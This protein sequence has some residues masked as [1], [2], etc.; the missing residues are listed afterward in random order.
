MERPPGSSELRETAR[1]WA[2]P[3]LWTC[4]TAAWLFSTLFL[5]PSLE[6]SLAGVL[7]ENQQQWKVATPLLTSAAV[8]QLCLPLVLLRVLL[9]G[10]VLKRVTTILSAIWL[11]VLFFYCLADLFLFTRFGRHITDVLAYLS[12]PEGA[13]AG[14]GALGWWSTVASLLGWSLL[15]AGV[16]LLLAHAFRLAMVRLSSSMRALC[17]GCALLAVLALCAS[18]WLLAPLMPDALRSRVYPALALRPGL[19]FGTDQ[20]EPNDPQLRKLQ[21]ELQRHYGDLFSFVYG[22]QEAD[23]LESL[24]DGATNLSAPNVSIVVAESLRWEMLSERHMPRLWRLAQEGLS[25]SRHYAATNHSE[26]GLFVLLYG[27]SALRYNS[28]LDQ[29]TPPSLCH[30]VR[31]LGYRC[32]YY[33]GHPQIWLR[34]EEF[35]NAQT[36]D[37]FVHD[38]SGE[39]NDWDRRALKTAS[40]DLTDG[41]KR[42]ALTFLMSSHF[43]YQYPPE[44]ERFTPADR[45]EHA[46]GPAKTKPAEF[47][48]ARNRYHNVL[49]FL[50]DLVADHIESLDLSKTLVIFTGDHGES[51]GED[52]RFGHG[53]GFSDLLTRVPFFMVGAGIEKRSLTTRSS[54]VDILPSILAALGGKPR[55]H[56]AGQALQTPS[57]EDRALLSAYRI[58]S[59][60]SIDAQLLHKQYRLRL[61]LNPSSPEVFVVGFEDAMGQVLGVEL[62]DALI[63]E[64]GGAFR[65]QLELVGRGP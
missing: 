8:A 54:H 26:T 25:S 10:R 40:R 21:H 58:R 50:D 44:Y 43:E 41:T 35:L 53:Y 6:E 33:T 16:Y 23:P 1:T 9:L 47:E 59:N 5:R 17:L 38:D 18:T 29:K 42:I 64:L 30:L 36:M 37:D 62:S 28:A 14:G 34:R 11:S 27:Q 3:E 63:S 22:K 48:S 57:H 4:F 61:R 2:A 65:N 49:G 60:P 13:Q 31:P 51:T 20:E 56:R 55:L 39:W 45:P 24:D 7:S 52:G 46:W 32:G 15:C 19:S 12:M